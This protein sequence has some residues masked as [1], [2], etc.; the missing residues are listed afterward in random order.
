MPNQFKQKKTE[1]PAHCPVPLKYRVS[2]LRYTEMYSYTLFYVFVLY[3][4]KQKRLWNYLFM[5]QAAVL[6]CFGDP[7][8]LQ[9][10]F[11][12]SLKPYSAT[13]SIMLF[14]FMQCKCPVFG[15]LFKKRT[16]QPDGQKK[17]IQ[18]TLM[19]L[20]CPPPLTPFSSGLSIASVKGTLPRDGYF[21]E[22]LNIVISTFWVWADGFQGLSKDFLF[23][24]NCLLIL[25]EKIPTG[26][27]L[28]IPFAMIGRCSPAPA[29]HWL[30]AKCARINS[31]QA[32]FG[33]ILQN[34][35]QLLVWFYRITGGFL[36]ASSVSKSPL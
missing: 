1:N 2:P 11:N 9:F 3:F 6:C 13:E 28:R 20:H 30:Q 32:A 23:L 26:T 29:S 7:N 33:M 8:F 22:G 24:W 4:M 21:F 17:D 27:F 34:H 16:V 19:W 18:A 25:K 5:L 12:F 35:R 36:W 31:S 15:I 14:M 10:I